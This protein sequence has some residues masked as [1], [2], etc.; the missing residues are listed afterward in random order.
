MPPRR[1]SR[2]SISSP[3]GAD[4]VSS[5]SLAEVRDRLNRNNALLNSPLFAN[6]QPN[7]PPI[8]VGIGVGGPGPSSSSF[9]PIHSPQPNHSD[10][11]KEKLLLAREA[12]L[13]R[14]Q[15]LMLSNIH[16]KDEN[17]D[18]EPTS[19]NLN[20]SSIGND[21]MKVENGQ[22]RI[23]SPNNLNGGRSGKARVLN[24]IRE[25]ECNLAKN[26]LILPIDQTLHL[27]QRDY[28]NATALSL[29]H[30]TINQTRSSSPK[31]RNPYN[32]FKAKSR[33]GG[34]Q[35]QNQQ[36]NDLFNNQDD[37]ITRANRLARLNAFMSYKGSNSDN[38]DLEEEDD[39]HDNDENNGYYDEDDDDD[40]DDLDIKE[41]DKEEYINRLIK[42][43]ESN[44]DRNFELSGPASGGYDGNGL[45]LRSKNEI[46]EEIDEFGEDDEIFAEGN[47]EYGNGTGQG[48]LAAGPGR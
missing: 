33:F 18:I 17:M 23:K 31:P 8:G 35:E 1:S 38:E 5:L 3:T 15:E 43:T 40:D 45:P 28:Q 27:G 13:A 42:E 48:S 16:L 11:V 25:D 41:D 9:S 30:L 10:P 22:E 37:E 44:G 26:G 32:K 12:L 7:S 46:G 21:G 24:K 14:E 29:S 6:Q 4:D 2:T 20:G 19:P 34:S 47:D 36:H 39:D